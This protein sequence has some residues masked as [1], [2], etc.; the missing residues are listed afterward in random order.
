MA[1]QPPDF[2]SFRSQLSIQSELITS[3]ERLELYRKDTTETI[4]SCVAA[5]ECGNRDDLIATLKFCN[6]QSLSFTVRGAGTGLSGGA[7]PQGGI[8]ISTTRMNQIE[9]DP[10]R[11]VIRCGPGAITK[12]IQSAASL[13]G[14]TYPPDPASYAESTIAGNIAEN[15]GGLRCK[16][17]GVTRDYVIGLE[18]ILP[19]G[20][21]LHTGTLSDSRGLNWGDVLT[22]SEGTLGII[23]KIELQAIPIPELGTSILSFFP[24][25]HSAGKAVSRIVAEGII[26][27]VLEFMDG[28]AV[29]TVFTELEDRAFFPASSPVLLIE[30]D[31]RRDPVQSMRIAA[32]CNDT[33]CTWSR[34]ESD[35]ARS[36]QLW[37]LRR[38]LSRAVK[39]KWP[40][41]LSE[42]VAVPVSKFSQLVEIASRLKKPPEMEVACFGH[43][44][45]G[46]LHAVFMLKTDTPAG[47]RLV[48]G[49]VSILMDETVKLR[50]TVTGEHGIGLSK[51]EFL[52]REFD[53]S[54]IHAMR[55]FKQLLDPEDR[56]NPEKIF[57]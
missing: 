9:V 20:E 56:C 4:G 47:R 41:W 10:I 33:G 2:E 48:D 12:D 3:S 11:Q 19:S 37:V 21:I 23:T 49:Q 24:D 28:G 5:I 57:Q 52:T 13:H 25:V 39:K 53:A 34:M 44:G 16:R 50:G 45:D 42:D 29:E 43:A 55:L 7:T 38:S 27:T 14:L 30:S 18:T 51:R 40:F 36:E 35:P 26:P 31:S 54:T 1:M 22:G 8:V 46:N 17:F 15:A 6:Q 32:I